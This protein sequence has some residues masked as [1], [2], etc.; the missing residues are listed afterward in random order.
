MPC[1]V[2]A[3]LRT[4]VHTNQLIQITAGTQFTHPTLRYGI[5]LSSERN[6]TPKL[7]LIQLI[8]LLQR[9]DTHV[10]VLENT[11]RD[12]C[13]LL[14]YIS[15]LAQTKHLNFDP[16]LL[17]TTYFD[18]LTQSSNLGPPATQLSSLVVFDVSNQSHSLIRVFTPWYPR[19]R[20]VC[21]FPFL[22]AAPLPTKCIFA[23]GF[24]DSR[25]CER[26]RI[27]GVALKRSPHAP[28]A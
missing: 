1:V 10:G 12:E 9:R 24:R 4:F 27:P 15:W 16:Y 11:L 17:H 20:I 23:R 26:V 28:R 5:Q 6:F 13:T 3:L 19:G 14:F 22:P 8:L 18:I 25:A 21:P 2:S 7:R